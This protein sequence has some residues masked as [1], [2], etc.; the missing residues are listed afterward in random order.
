MA[1]IKLAPSPKVT[2]RDRSKSPNARAGV[3]PRC[4]NI[5]KSL[6]RAIV[7]VTLLL[8][9]KNSEIRGDFQQ[10]SFLIA[11]M[12]LIISPR[13]KDLIYIKTQSFSISSY[14]SRMSRPAT[15][16]S[17]SSAYLS[18]NG[19][20]GGGGGGGGGCCGPSS[21]CSSSGPVARANS[22]SRNNK[23]N[24]NNGHSPAPRPTTHRSISLQVR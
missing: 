18:T 6:F 21:C 23:I 12:K 13:H 10:K 20:G 5:Q 17:S 24:N 8:L 14:L 22:S 16:S 4:V 1:S 7:A 2:R 15:H 11:E 3:G 9:T 19:R